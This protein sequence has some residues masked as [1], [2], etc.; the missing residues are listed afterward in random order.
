[1]SEDVNSTR[2]QLGVREDST[3]IQRFIAPTQWKRTLFYLFGDAVVVLGASAVTY[4][5][6]TH[7]LTI[8]LGYLLTKVFPYAILALGFQIAL[9]FILSNYQLKWSTFSL[10]DVPRVAFPAILTTI[11]IGGLSATGLFATLSPWSALTWG[12]LNISGV[13]A[14]RMGKRFY[15]EV[16]RRKLGKRAVLVVSSEKGYFLLDV[17]H[18]IN[19][20]PYRIIGFV[21]P[22][23]C[24]KGAVVGGLKVLGTFDEIEEIVPKNKVEAAFIFLSS[25]PRYPVSKLYQKLLDLGVQT[26]IIPSFTDLL[27]GAGN[28]G[29]ESF[30]SIAVHELTGRPPVVVN[31]EEMEMVFGGKRILV[32]GAGGSI[33]S[34]LCRQLANFNIAELILFERDDSNLFYIEDELRKSYPRLKIVPY[35]GDITDE[36]SVNKAFQLTHP[37]IVFH[38]A[39]YKHVP[40]LEY[41]PDEAIRVNVFGSHIVA[42]TAVEHKCESF[43]YIS[44]DKAVN[45]KSVMGATKRLGEMVVISMNGMGGVRFVAVRFG[46]VL[47]SRGSVLTLFTKAIK[48][49]KPIFITH[50][51]MERY[52]MLTSEAV[53]LV[54]QA[55]AIGKGGE[56]FVLDMGKRVKVKEI[57][58]ILIRS[59]GLE[60]NVDIPIIETGIRPGEKITE[61]L[62]TDEEGIVATVKKRI[63]MARPSIKNS[64]PEITE[65]LKRFERLLEN[66]DPRQIRLELAKQVKSYQPDMSWLDL[67]PLASSGEVIGDL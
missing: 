34:E 21:D 4:M 11:V 29:E 53:L 31:P 32:T 51:E 67:S 28:N 24:N 14:V 62:L 41:H 61:E 52:F 9:G 35:L 27:G 36:K 40:I 55:S 25:N 57:A 23:P 46:N 38:A 33:G 59:A 64:Y 13:I 54:M 30:A 19:P 42:R 39:A 50:P 49:K 16:I 6:A 12:L 1:M 26:R 18:R 66:P 17:L 2:H 5:V 56:I 20:F 58:E 60:P 47:A 43:V 48:N 63:L 22:E 3:P 65:E 37:H 15:Q 10:Q 7:H 8:K 44:T 45:P